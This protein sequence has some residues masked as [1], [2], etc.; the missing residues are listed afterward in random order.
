MTSVDLVVVGA[1]TAGLTA[2]AVAAADGLQVLVVE[3][4]A[5]GGQIATVDKIRNFPGFPDGIGGYELGPL[6]QQQGADVGVDFL[7]DTVEGI[8]PSAN[9]FVVRCAETTLE[10][11][12]V[13]LAMGSRRRAL[14]VPGEADL[15]GR[16][17]SHCASCDGHF[18]RGKTVV[19][20]GG[21]DSAFDEAEVLAGIAKDVVIVHESAKPR[22]Q[23]LT[24]ERVSALPN[25]RILPEARIAA[26]GGTQEVEHIIVDG[27]GGRS[28][29][30]AAGL[31]VYVGLIPNSAIV[32]GLV[33]TDDAGAIIADRDFQTAVPG[34]FVAGD[35][36]SGAR[37]LLASAAG[38]GA[39]AAAA[40]VRHIRQI[41]SV[42]EVAA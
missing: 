28:E 11:R 21:G 8:D 31:F 27:P 6:L 12:A 13:I 19:V 40:A 1:G 30:P 2:A 24:V 37:A 22:A 23:R 42:G 15:E 14:D 39:S 26:V 34:L 3:Q 9:G 29:E 18:F 16:G 7:L 20:A 33:E 10:A 17:V 41:A 35:L 36:R 32:A 4:L 5:P 38:D 25:V